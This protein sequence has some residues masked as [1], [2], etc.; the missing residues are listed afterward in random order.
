[1]VGRISSNYGMF[2]HFID[3]V[4]SWVSE[5]EAGEGQAPPGICNSTVFS[6]KGR[7]LGFEWV[8]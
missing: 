5:G 8:K 3:N 1:M 6:K 2:K 7:F 4:P